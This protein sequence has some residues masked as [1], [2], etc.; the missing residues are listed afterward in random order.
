MNVKSN[1]PLALITG[2]SSGI[3]RA[4]A[5]ALAKQNYDLLLVSNRE[6]QLA[7][8]QAAIAKMYSVRCDTLF[9]DLADPKAAEKLFQYC[10]ERQMQVGLLINNAGMLIF[11]EM[12]AVEPQRVQTILQLHMVTLTMLC[13]LFGAEMKNGKADIF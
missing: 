13:R 9:M 6:D 1:Q 11:S 12:T 4:M 7:E 10:E 8:V 3:G 5:E 2:G